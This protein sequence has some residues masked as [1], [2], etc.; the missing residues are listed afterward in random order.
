MPAQTQ[1]SSGSGPESGIV[2]FGND[3]FAENR[4][5]SHHIARRLAG[6]SRLLYV[7]SP[8]MRAPVASSRD[9]RRIWTKLAQALRRPREILPGL[10][11]CT[12]PQLPWRKAPGIERIN[13]IFGAWAVRRAMRHVGITR[14]IL[15]FVLP[16]PGFMLDAVPHELAIYYCIDDYAAHPGVDAERIRACDDMLTR[17][18]DH[19]FVAP[20]ALLAAK[21]A[22]NPNTSFA[23]HG[24]DV[25]LF[26]SAMDATTRVPAV[27]ARLAH[28]VI[29]YFGSIAAWTDLELLEALARQRP[30]WSLLLV[31]HASVNVGSLAQLPNVTMVGAQPYESLPGWAKAFDVA[32]IPYRLNEQVRNA[33]PLKLREYLATGKPVVSVR[34]PEVERFASMLHIGEDVPGFISAVEAALREIGPELGSRRIEAVSD[35]SWEQRAD[36]TMAIVRQALARRA[37]GGAR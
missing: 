15:W 22:A 25:R 29:G 11:H 5:S 6:H 14:P 12:V 3:W 18:A 24:V 26:S 17:R 37:G 16:H 23:P 36:A 1:G 8:G 4:T 28:P 30:Q 20:P 35:M 33:N 7:D 2:Y 19:V 13:R 27:A 32:I 9:L 31:G 10:W 34:T 21:T